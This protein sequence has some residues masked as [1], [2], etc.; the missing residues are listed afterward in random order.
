M[1]HVLENF[2]LQ[3]VPKASARAVSYEIQQ[4]GVEIGFITLG[5]SNWTRHGRQPALGFGI[6]AAARGKKHAAKAVCMLTRHAFDTL[7]MDEL[8]V[9]TNINNISCQRTMEKTGYMLCAEDEVRPGSICYR[10][11]RATWQLPQFT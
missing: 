10:A 7:G 3:L 5:G 4:G 6:Y 9:S 11:S 2:G 1:T 8:I